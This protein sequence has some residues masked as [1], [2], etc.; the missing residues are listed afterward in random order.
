M[1][2]TTISMSSCDK[3]DSGKPQLEKKVVLH[4][5][6]PEMYAKNNPKGPLL[7]NLTTPAYNIA[8][9]TDE[10]YSLT[11]GPQVDDAPL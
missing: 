6:K 5:L 1:P 11:S 3:Y 9:P 8:P 2:A 7:N 4:T 10:E